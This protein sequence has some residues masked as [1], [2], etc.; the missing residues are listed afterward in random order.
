MLF[1]SCQDTRMSVQLCCSFSDPPGFLWGFCSI[2]GQVRWERGLMRAGV[3][4]W[5]RGAAGRVGSTSGRCCRLRA[6]HQ[7][8]VPE[9][10]LVERFGACLP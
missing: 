2:T 9:H 8:D 3:A 7:P 6:E 1:R 10:R 5:Q 4:V